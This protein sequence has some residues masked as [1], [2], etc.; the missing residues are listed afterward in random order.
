MSVGVVC[1]WCVYGVCVCVCVWCFV[2]FC[3]SSL[4]GP[5]RHN[6][7]SDR[8]LA[9]TEH[10]CDSVVNRVPLPDWRLTISTCLP[11]KECVCVF[12]HSFKG[13]VLV[14]AENKTTNWPRILRYRHKASFG[15]RG[16][17]I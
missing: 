4:F 16:G 7:Q 17:G 2:F 8:G 3:S 10:L 11:S 13:I 14:K 15:V 5:G 9:K 12:I 1:V 6:F